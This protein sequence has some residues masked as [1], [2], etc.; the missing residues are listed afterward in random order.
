[1]ILNVAQVFIFKCKFS[2]AKANVKFEYK[3]PLSSMRNKFGIFKEEDY[4]GVIIK[5]NLLI[6][7]R[8]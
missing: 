5:Q 3:H 2:R 1:M 4:H 7:V 8:S 6:C